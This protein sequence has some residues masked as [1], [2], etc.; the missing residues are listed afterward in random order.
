MQEQKLTVAMGERLLLQGSHKAGKLFNG[1]IV[2]AKEIK[3]DGSMVLT[4]N[5]VIPPAFKTFTHG[6]CVTS[7]ASQGR[8]VDHVFVAMDSQSFQAANK[9]QFYVSVSRGREQVK[10][11]TDDA[12]FLR[13]MVTKPG[14]R[15]SAIE[16]LESQRLAATETTSQRQAV[17]VRVGA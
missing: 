17:K 13:T 5:R 1:Q 7:H 12:E 8:T 2:T 16:L 3:P 10:I 6:Y 15:L 9:N 4:D 14:A 11:F